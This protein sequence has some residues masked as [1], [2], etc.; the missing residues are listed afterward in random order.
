MCYFVSVGVRAP[1]R[2]LTQVF[3]EETEFDIA[4]APVC[5]AV[6]RAFPA[7]DEVCLVTWRGCSCDLVESRKRPGSTKLLAAFQ[8]SVIGLV[9][10][11]GDVR[12]LVH[13]HREPCLMPVPVAGLPLTVYDFLT[14]E[15]WFVEDVVMEI[16]ER[17]ARQN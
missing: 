14:Q 12:L 17:P 3:N 5:S 10:R 4:V 2:L 13:S 1:A 11:L 6:Q 8:T 16:S 15:S 9:R 7:E